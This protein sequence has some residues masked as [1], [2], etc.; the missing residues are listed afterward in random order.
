MYTSRVYTSWRGWFQ[1]TVNSRPM[2]LNTFV[3]SISQASLNV[4]LVV[5]YSLL[6]VLKELNQVFNSEK[7]VDTFS[8]VDKKHYNVVVSFYGD[9]EKYV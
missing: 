9:Q 5:L 4:S 7:S 1:H 3:Y 6:F 8:M 2:P